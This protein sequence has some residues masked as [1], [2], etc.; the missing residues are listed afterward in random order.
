MC[1]DGYK[2]EQ[3]VSVPK[4]LGNEQPGNMSRTCF[5][6][7][8]PH[9]V[10]GNDVSRNDPIT[11]LKDT[12][13]L[14]SYCTPKKPRNAARDFPYFDFRCGER[15]HPRAMRLAL[16]ELLVASGNDLSLVPWLK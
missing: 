3:I 11:T 12:N 1:T 7:V 13:P 14:H 15:L 2:K 10:T 16:R 6:L 4:H 8:C 9:C 5:P